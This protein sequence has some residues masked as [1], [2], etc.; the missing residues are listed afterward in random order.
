MNKQLAQTE[1]L[2]SG[3]YSGTFSEP[4]CKNSKRR[5]SSS[6]QHSA[7]K[8]EG[9]LRVWSKPEQRSKT[10]CQCKQNHKQLF[11]IVQR[12]PPD[13]LH[14]VLERSCLRLKKTTHKPQEA[15]ETKQNLV[16]RWARTVLPHACISKKDG[17]EE[18]SENQASSKRYFNGLSSYS[19]ASYELSPQATLVYAGVGF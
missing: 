13:Q 1:C 2:L 14:S 3:Q 7:G 11:S 4:I 5:Q 10:L 8:E 12:I 17:G 6:C 15:H 16:T 18:L 19:Q 9:L